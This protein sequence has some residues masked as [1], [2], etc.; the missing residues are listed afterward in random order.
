M[1]ITTNLTIA[2]QAIRVN[3][4]RSSLTMLGIIIGVAAVI[5]MIAVGSG[6]QARIK[7]QISSLGSNLMI[8]IPGSLLQSGVR[9]GTGLAQTLTEE[10]AR[11]LLMEIPEIAFAASVSR[12]GGQI[13]ANNS[14]WATTIYG[15][16]PDFFEVREWPLASGRMFESGELVG[17]A[18]VVILGYTVANQL[19]GTWD[20][21]DQQVRIK[22]VPFTIIGIAKRKGQ[23]IQ[24][25]DQD[26]GVFV[27]LST[28][29]NRIFGEAMGTIAK[30]DAIAVKVQEGNNM[31]GVEQKIVELLRQ[32]HR[33]QTGAE[34][35]FTI[36]NLTDIL[37]TQ[38]AASKVMSALLAAVAS[39]SLLVGGIG[40][41]NIMLVSVT[42]RTR[43]IGLRMAVG[44]RAKDILE[45]FMVEAVT[46]T[47]LGGALGVLI[48]FLASQLLTLFTGW[49][50]ELS[51][52]SIILAV[53]F[54]AVIGI[55]FGYYPAKKASLMQ[56]V[57]ALHY[58]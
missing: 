33:I 40:I 23:S 26:D 15:V 52:F 29:R 36:R 56:P 14:N 30:V 43:E 38:E 42:E 48:G 18:K 16:N 1:K 27:P 55:F 31:K 51:F 37:Q 45:Q 19:F 21:I 46:L 53:G 6:A 34:D 54:S 25:Q 17:S 41:M 47:M 22:G 10:D 50:V 11:F 28:A 4:L 20:P 24:G 58:E 9:L 57:Q 8:I 2:V 44:A 13:I 7:A 39:V 3:K 35:D 5:T 49:P 12:G 32:R